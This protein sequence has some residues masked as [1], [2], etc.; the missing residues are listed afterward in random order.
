MA[1]HC[2]TFTLKF[3]LSVSSSEKSPVN[4]RTLL[5]PRKLASVVRGRLADRAML[6]RA[7]KVGVERFK[8][9]PNYRPDLVP[10]NFAPHKSPVGDDSALLRRI[11]AAYQKAKKDQKV[12]RK[13][14][15]SATSGFPFMSVNC[16]WSW[17]P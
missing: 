16:V 4:L 1:I 13:R 8:D 15:T 5:K 9:D 10:A 7:I 11:V 12:Q 17:K 6:N 14:S 3:Y 2:G